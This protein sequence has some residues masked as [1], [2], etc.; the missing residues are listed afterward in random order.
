MTAQELNLL[1]NYVLDYDPANGGVWLLASL[2]DTGRVHVAQC[3]A[4]AAVAPVVA[5]LRVLGYNVVEAKERAD[6]VELYRISYREPYPGHFM[7]VHHNGVWVPHHLL[8]IQ[9]SQ[10]T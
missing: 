7:E 4:Q 6:S 3:A 2:G 9:P 1:M 5:R 8:N 10:P